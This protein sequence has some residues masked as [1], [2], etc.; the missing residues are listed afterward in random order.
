MKALDIRQSLQHLG[1]W[2]SLLI[3][4][5]TYRGIRIDALIVDIKTRWIRGF[6]IKM[7]RSDFLQDQKWEQYSEF[8]SSLSI[9]CPDGLIRK[10][11]VSDPFGLLYVTPS[12]KEYM[13]PTF[14]W[15]KKPKRYQTRKGLA[16]MWI[17]L[18][19][20]EAELPR[21]SQQNIHLQRMLEWANRERDEVK[22]QP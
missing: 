18:R 14:R 7:S 2:G 20:L 6:E 3:P 11:E 12:K 4:E 5:F 22:P 1:G 13:N 17:Y 10:E 19:V 8:C 21:L 15:I 16:W 9:A